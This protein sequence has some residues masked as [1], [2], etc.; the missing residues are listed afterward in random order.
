MTGMSRSDAPVAIEG[1]GLELRK[2][3]LGGDMTAAFVRLAKG[4]TSVR[5]SS[6]CPTTASPARTGATCCPDGCACTPGPDPRT[7]R[8]VR[9][10]TGAR[11]THRKRSRT[12]STSTS[13]PHGSSGPSSSTSRANDMGA[14]RRPARRRTGAWPASRSRAAGTAP[15]S[16]S[17]SWAPAACRRSG[18]RPPDRRRRSLSIDGRVAALY[19]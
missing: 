17:G 2:R 6:A 9:P 15:T 13:P 1:D 14:W 18:S 11:G 3:E 4:P 8:Q 16:Q 10:S 19:P 7:T 12:P 5:R